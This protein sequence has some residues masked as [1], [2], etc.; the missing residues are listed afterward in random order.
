MEMLKK[1]IEQGISIVDV[2]EEVHDAYNERLDEALSQ[3]IWAYPGMTTYY[4]NS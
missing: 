1:M 2:K 4:R 3:T